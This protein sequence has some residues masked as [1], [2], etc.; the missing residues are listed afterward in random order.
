MTTPITFQ[1]AEY[2]A[3]A[4]GPGRAAEPNPYTE[5]VQAIALEVTTDGKPVA[6]AFQ[7]EHP[8]RTSEKPEDVTELKRIEAKIKRQFSLAGEQSSPKVTVKSDISPVTNPVNGK[9]SATKS[10]VTFWTVKRQERPRK[11]KTVETP[12]S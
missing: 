3:P 6:K 2:V 5:I 1:D 11:P 9:A 4:G 12:A 8:S 10:V 7:I